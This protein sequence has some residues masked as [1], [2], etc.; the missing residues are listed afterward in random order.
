MIRNNP[1][2]TQPSQEMFSYKNNVEV[3]ERAN[4][5]DAQKEFI[6]QNYNNNG[7]VFQLPGVGIIR[8]VMK[9]TKSGDAQW[10]FPQL[11]NFTVS[12]LSLIQNVDSGENNMQFLAKNAGGIE[13]YIED[14]VNI[15]NETKDFREALNSMHLVFKGNVNDLQDVK[16][17]IVNEALTSEKVVYK[18]AGF[19][20]INGEFVYITNDGALKKNG[21]FDE[22]L[23]VEPETFKSVIKDLELVTQEEVRINGEF[24]YITNDGALK[25]NGVFDEELRV[26]PETFKSVIKDLELVTQEEVRNIKNALNNFNTPDIVYPILGSSMAY[27]FT[28]FFN[29]S[30]DG[31][32]HILFMSGESDSG[33]N[34]TL[35]HVIKP[36]LNMDYK[37]ES[38]SNATQANFNRSTDE[39]CTLP[40]VYDEH[41]LRNLRKDRKDMIYTWIR[42]TTEHTVT[43]RVDKKSTHKRIAYKTQAPLIMLGENI[44]SDVSI[45]NRCNLVFFSKKKRMRVDKKSTHKRIAYKT[46]APLIMLGENIP[47]DVSIL[48]R[49]NLVFFSK[50]KRESNADYEKNYLHL[51]DNELLL[52]KIGYTVKRYILECYDK[53]KFE[54]EL[55][56]LKRALSNFKIGSREFK[57]FKDCVFGVQVL[58]NALA[59][60]TGEVLFDNLTAVAQHIY[61]NILANVTGGGTS[62]EADYIEV[63]ENIDIMIQEGRLQEGWH[64][65]FD[66][67]NDVIKI[68]FKRAYI[69]FLA[70]CKEKNISDDTMS[71]KEF[72]RK[73]TN[74]NFVAGTSSKDYYKKQRLRVSVG[75]SASKN[76]YLLKMSVCEAFG[77]LGLSNQ[78]EKDPHDPSY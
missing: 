23:R 7:K 60:Y 20:K 41:T 33:K 52:R 78:I 11:T 76:V 8:A 38:C 31:K 61:D 65:V 45:L 71:S 63:L 16:E 62:A 6:K 30:N 36:L 5:I 58:N 24:V 17:L 10:S 70:F 34:K 49:C 48:N 44:P 27:N 57:T 54:T 14:S 26:E 40:I 69:E 43:M 59:H 72:I 66:T 47:S 28:S 9:Q 68:D 35:D 73:L 37:S 2:Q 46:Q 1:G 50:K 4:A 74:S 56:Q 3:C 67:E 42:T 29:E 19:R 13:R 39:S 22:E 12:D 53:D 51:V 75:K 64:Y 25:K 77:F 21:V 32:L 18:T 55:K 15:F